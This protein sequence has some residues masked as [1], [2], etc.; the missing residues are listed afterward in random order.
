MEDPP[1]SLIMMRAIDPV[2]GGGIGHVR[3]RVFIHCQYVYG[4]GHYVRA[5]EL[6]R[7]LSE[8]FDVFLL[9]GGEIVPNYGLPPRVTCLQLPA[10]YKKEKSN[11]LIP[12]DPSLNLDDCLRAR[13]SLLEQLVDRFEPDVL[14]TEHFPFG[15][16]FEKEVMALI[17]RVKRRKRSAKIV[18]SVRDVVESEKG[19]LRDEHICSVLNEW[20]DMILVHSD[21]RLIP[22]YS[23]FPLMAKIEIPLHYTGYVVQAITPRPS[24]A[25]PPLLVVSVGGGR[26][27]DELLYA[28]LSAHR[29]VASQWCH[30]TVLFTGAFQEDIQRLHRRLEEEGSPDITIHAFD[31]DDYRQTLA[32]AT[33]VICLGGYNSLLEAVSARLRVLIYERAF[34]GANR[35]QAL[36]AALFQRSGLIRLLSPDDLSIE[37]LAARILALSE[38]SQNPDVDVRIDGAERTRVLLERL[39]NGTP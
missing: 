32:V 21:D 6:A 12:V 30:Q 17:D 1:E 28:V 37:R 35:E 20:Y 4:I 36:R 23:S 16:L 14:I 19:S 34:H 9:N 11:H 39:L 13:Q 25:D 22:F 31:R 24:R 18:S 26:M 33:G 10:I 38:R 27:G 2:E 5:V 29:K 15:N 3:P 8:Q 7:G